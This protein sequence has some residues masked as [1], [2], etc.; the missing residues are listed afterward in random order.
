MNKDLSNMFPLSENQIVKGNRRLAREK[1][2]QIIAAC[3]ISG[4]E[5]ESI[6]N[7]VF[8]RKFNLADSVETHVDHLLTRAEIQEMESDT[9]IHWKDDEIEFSKMLIRKT[10]EGETLLD[11]LI[12]KAAKNWELE[13]IAILDRILMQ[14]AISELLYFDEI[15]PKVSVN[16]AIEIAKKYSTEKSGT[17]ING[18]LDSILNTLKDEKKISKSGRGLKE[19]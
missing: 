10:L 9:P 19:S 6:F 5:P 14:M 8:F 11:E 15:P 16:E 18:V 13:R 1:T 7:H 17:F 4:E 12:D 3:R 2:L